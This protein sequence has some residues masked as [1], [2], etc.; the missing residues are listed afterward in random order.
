MDELRTA[1]LANWKGYEKL[2][3]GFLF[4]GKNLTFTAAL[5]APKWGNNKDAVDNIF[6]HV[7][8][9]YCKF[10]ANG[11]N[12]LGKPYDPSMLGIC[13]FLCL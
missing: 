2:H 13:L 7:Y 8:D 3:E 5:G 6:L 4:P 11:I 10:V 9:S 12:Y 1:L